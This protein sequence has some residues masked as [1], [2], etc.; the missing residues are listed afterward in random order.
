MGGQKEGREGKGSEEKRREGKGSEEKGREGRRK[1]RHGKGRERK[2]GWIRET[3]IR[4][5]T[6]VPS[7]IT[8]LPSFLLSF[9]ANIP[10]FRP[11][12]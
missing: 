8:F 12:P 1:G 10:S 2:E 3:I 6:S 11:F 9:Y 7:L 4:N 5:S